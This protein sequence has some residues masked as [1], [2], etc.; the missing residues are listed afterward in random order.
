MNRKDLQRNETWEQNSCK[1]IRALIMWK[2]YV[3]LLENFVISL[4]VMHIILQ[5]KIT[6]ANV[7]QSESSM[8]STDCHEFLSFCIYACIKLVILFPFACSCMTFML[9]SLTKNFLFFYIFRRWR[10]QI[11]VKSAILFLQDAHLIGRPSLR[12]A[13]VHLVTQLNGITTFIYL[14]FIHQMC[15]SPVSN[16]QF[17][18]YQNFEFNRQLSIKR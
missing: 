18:E 1:F 17:S 15:Q 11:D 5:L 2:K 6:K 12:N 14:L 9:F 13:F 8:K 7:R 16:N 10:F 4:Y 3:I